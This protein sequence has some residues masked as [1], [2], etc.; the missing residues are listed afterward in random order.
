MTAE[1]EHLIFGGAIVVLALFFL[2][3]YEKSK[4]AGAIPSAAQIAGSTGTAAYIPAVGQSQPIMSASQST[5]PGVALN[6]GA[7]PTYLTYNIPPSLS[8]QL[9]NQVNPAMEPN[10]ETTYQGC[11][12][13]ANTVTPKT[14]KT[15]VGS[16]SVTQAAIDNYNNLQSTGLLP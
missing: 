11:C 2:W 14:F 8:G 10:G 9:Q 12:N 16:P 6:I 13:D 5:V 4:T 15:F 7:S 3:Y 1:K